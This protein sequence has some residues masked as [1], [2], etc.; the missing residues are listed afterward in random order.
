[1]LLTQHTGWLRLRLTMPKASG[2]AQA[3]TLQGKTVMIEVLLF[4]AWDFSQLER[5]LVSFK[6]NA[7][8]LKEIALS[9]Y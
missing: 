1:M 8:V 2:V 4:Q 6:E 5:P 7:K 3:E 9:K